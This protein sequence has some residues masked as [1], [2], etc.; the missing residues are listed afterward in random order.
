MHDALTMDAEV[1]VRN[2]QLVAQKAFDKVE[3]GRQ[4]CATQLK[5]VSDLGTCSDV[6]DW[7]RFK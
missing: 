7:D 3:I 6:S 4:L 5:S 2:Q 1:T